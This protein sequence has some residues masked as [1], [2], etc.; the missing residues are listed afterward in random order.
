MGVVK[1]WSITCL[2]LMTDFNCCFAFGGHNIFTCLWH[3]KTYLTGSDVVQFDHCTVYTYIC[4][5]ERI[6]I[7]EK[8][9][10]PVI[11]RIETM[12]ENTFDYYW[13]KKEVNPACYS[14]CGS[15]HCLLTSLKLYHHLFERGIT[16]P[17]IY[18]FNGEMLIAITSVMVCRCFFLFD[19]I[20]SRYFST[21]Y[22]TSA[23]YWFSRKNKVG[24]PVSWGV[25]QIVHE[26]WCFSF[27]SFSLF[28]YQLI[29]GS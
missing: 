4:V 13:K 9:C 14:Y 24:K 6:Y 27:K 7:S 1:M 10:V 16:P 21:Y 19:I 11:V 28:G 3:V 26:S 23:L 22:C 20:P 18:I 25:K 2:W 12:M 5:S 8:C 29:I 17:K 15:C